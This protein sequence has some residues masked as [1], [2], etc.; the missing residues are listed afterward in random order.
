MGKVLND[1]AESQMIRYKNEGVRPTNLTFRKY[2]VTTAETQLDEFFIA[3]I[4]ISVEHRMSNSVVKHRSRFIGIENT[5][6]STQVQMYY[7]TP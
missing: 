4:G 3:S 2:P 1:Y 5:L 6:L 7:E